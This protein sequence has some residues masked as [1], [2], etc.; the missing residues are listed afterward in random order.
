[1][2]LYNSLSSFLVGPC[3]ILKSCNKVS[4]EPSLLQA[5]QPQ[6]SQSF[7]T[8]EV[9]QP[10]NH[11]RGLLWPHSNRSIS[12]VCWGL[13]SWT[14][15]SWWALTRAEQR[16]R[17]P[18][19]DLLAT[20]LLMQPR[21]WLAFWAASAHCR[22]MLSFSSTSTPKSFSS[23]LLSV[24]PAPSL[25]LCLGLPWPVCRTLHLVFWTSW[26]W[27]RLTSQACRGPSRWISFHL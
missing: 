18:S 23:G 1:M 6:L 3:Q 19:L 17:V 7:L 11:F 15:G 21:V 2:P 14:Q 4:P 8:T 26:V 13:Q 20:M 25:Y 10:S 24:H 5:E 16:G 9:F 27:H 22:V 12:F